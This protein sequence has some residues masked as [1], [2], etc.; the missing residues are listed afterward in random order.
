MPIRLSHVFH[1][2]FPAYLINAIPRRA[3][4]HRVQEPLVALFTP[5]SARGPSPQVNR[6]PP[7]LNCCSL[8]GILSGVRIYGLS[9]SIQHAD[10]WIGLPL[11]EM[12]RAGLDGPSYR[13]KLESEL[14]KHC[15][16]I[17]I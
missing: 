11:S 2:Y 10:P 17:G 4:P 5:F 8:P 9:A 1:Q 15:L 13:D 7:K 12:N 16:H 3:I 6:S 14:A